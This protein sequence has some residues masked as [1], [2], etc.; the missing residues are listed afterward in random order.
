MGYKGYMFLA[1]A[2]GDSMRF[3]H[4]ANIGKATAITHSKQQS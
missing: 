3:R 4:D 1:A 2:V